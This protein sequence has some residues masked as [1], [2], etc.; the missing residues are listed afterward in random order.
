MPSDRGSTLTDRHLSS[1]R[2]RREPLIWRPLSMA[3][4]E[5]GALAISLQ[6]LCTPVGYEGGLTPAPPDHVNSP[7]TGAEGLP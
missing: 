7:R 4:G 1:V 6:A 5:S 3:A 2:H